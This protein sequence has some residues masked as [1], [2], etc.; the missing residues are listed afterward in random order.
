M[1]GLDLNKIAEGELYRQ[2][3]REYK[4]SLNNIAD[5]NTDPK[6]ARTITITLKISGDDRREMLFIDGDVKSKLAPSK[7]ISTT[8]LLG[9]HGDELIARELIAS[10]GQYSFADDGEVVDD[11][12]DK[13]EEGKVIDLVKQTKAK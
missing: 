11:L 3:Q 9:Q 6:K 8:M 5:P 2:L 4:R 13:V 12:G 10:P 1:S 7:A